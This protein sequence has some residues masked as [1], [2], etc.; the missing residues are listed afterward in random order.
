METEGVLFV[1]VQGLNELPK[2]SVEASA[3]ESGVT[4]IVMDDYLNIVGRSHVDKVKITR[5]FFF[6]CLWTPMSIHSSL[7]IER[8]D[9]YSYITRSSLL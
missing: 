7:K 8:D 2:N 9:S 4:F 1:A 5:P 6:F 3:S